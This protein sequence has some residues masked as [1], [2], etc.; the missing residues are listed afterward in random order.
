MVCKRQTTDPRVFKEAE[1]SLVGSG[2]SDCSGGYEPQQENRGA[3]DWERASLSATSNGHLMEVDNGRSWKD[4]REE[5]HAFLT[6]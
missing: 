4:E 1:E 6:D 5:R 3:T 2:I